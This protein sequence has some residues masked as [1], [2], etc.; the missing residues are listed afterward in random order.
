M[1]N[2]SLRYVLLFLLAFTSVYT[3]AQSGVYD[4]T[5]PALNQGDESSARLSKNRATHVN[6]RDNNGTE[7]GTVASPL[8]VNC[9]GC[10][11][12]SSVIASQ[13][14]GGGSPWLV[15]IGSLSS[16]A[17]ITV[18]QGTS[19]WVTSGGS[20][21]GTVDQGT[22]GSSPWL[23]SRNW[24]LSS[25]TDSV[26]VGNFPS[27]FGVTQSTSPWVVSAGSWPLP[28]GAASATNQTTQIA[29]LGT[30]IS[31][32]SNIQ[33]NQTNGTQTSIVS[34]TITA[35][36]GTNL[37][38][39]A[40]NLE[41]TQSA[42]KTATHTDLGTINT[43]LGSPFQAGGSVGNTSFGATQSTAANLNATVVGPSGVALGKDSSLTTIN[44]T[45][46]SPFQAGG[47][48]GNTTFGATQSGAWTTGRTWT[49]SSLTDSTIADL[50]DGY[51]NKLTSEV[52]KSQQA[53]D[54][55][56][57]G[58]F[59][60]GTMT[61]GTHAAQINTLGM[62]NVWVHLDYGTSDA[63]GFF[64]I[65]FDGTTWKTEY[66]TSFTNLDSNWPS[67]FDSSD[68]TFDW[69]CPVSGVHAFRI[70]NVVSTTGTLTYFL[71]AGPASQTITAIGGPVF[72]TMTVNQGTSPWVVDASG[73]TVPI[74]A[75]SLPLPTL[76][77]TS[78]NQTTIIGSLGQLHTDIT[79]S[80]PRA[81]TQTTSPWVTKDQSTQTNG[82]S[83]NTLSHVVGGVF[84]T[85]PATI[86]NGQVGSIQLDAS[87][88]VLARINVALP[89]GTA[90]IGHIIAD[91]SSAVI[92]HVIVDTAPTT[93]VTGTVTANQGGSAATTSAWP[94]NVASFG[95]TA[96]VTGAGASGSGI[97]RVTVSNDS[98]VGIVAGSAVIGHVIND[99]SSAVIGHVIV[100]TAPSTAVTN[101]GTFAVQAAQSGLYTVTQGG[102]GSDAVAWPVNVASFGD[103]SVKTGTG[104]GGV[105]VPRVTV[106]SDTQLSLGTNTGKTNIFNS[107]AL[108]T[109]ATTQNITIK[110]YTVTSGKT[111]YLQW[112]SLE[113]RPTVISATASILG[114]ASL[115]S[116]A[117]TTIASHTFANPTTSDVERIYYSFSEP[118]PIPSGQI[119]KAVAA[120]AAATSTT[121]YGN[122]GGYE[123]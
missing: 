99:A 25:G 95:S 73:H 87:Q 26:N 29:S 14:N 30:I 49:I 106:S 122:F 31:S 48:I 40:L 108:V 91:A 123:K 78:T 83:A 5:L 69:H 28:T 105:G 110:T 62:G 39:S 71:S 12:A 19:P 27:T 42:F 52:I 7:L 81:V 100:D 107:S 112:L 63:A 118:I 113:S 36:A 57:V 77:A 53:L 15:N 66:C 116:P 33:A 58:D 23:T 24:F 117:G 47:S 18:Y 70:H 11:S 115:E 6:I 51:G 97:P 20:G 104:T 64:E 46:G 9:T 17:S 61:S 21:G 54:V 45:L 8:N 90:V 102:S 98:T 41:S 121:W 13:G 109:A 34:G 16:L 2:T 86:S 93:T 74:S 82:A 89:A 37:N 120:P 65:S 38:T 85:S 4:D 92:G 32:L 44:S 1:K 76:A 88:N 75:V 114:I 3:F 119:I 101:A 35:N 79:S 60:S 56:N 94:V 10:S 43:T 72:G 111:F 67:S 103:T 22:G 50:A 96:V 55:V 68:T 84:N 59:T 80:E